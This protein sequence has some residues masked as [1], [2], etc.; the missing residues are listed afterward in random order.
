MKYR[1]KPVVIDAIQYDGKN[2]EEIYADCNEIN[3]SAGLVHSCRS[4]Q[5][6]MILL[7]HPNKIILKQQKIKKIY[8]KV[9]KK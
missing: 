8:N 9:H 1:K 7:S 3:I 6:H 5:H 2:L 4:M